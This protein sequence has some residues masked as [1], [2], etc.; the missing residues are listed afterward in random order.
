MSPNLYFKMLTICMS[1][2]ANVCQNLPHVHLQAPS[3]DLTARKEAGSAEPLSKEGRAQAVRAAVTLA[4]LQEE[5]AWAPPK[6]RALLVSFGEC[7]EE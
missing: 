4:V 7:R 6:I 2:D 1:L 3:Q 5:P